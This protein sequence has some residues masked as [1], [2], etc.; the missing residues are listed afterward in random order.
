MAMMVDAGHDVIWID[1]NHDC[2]GRMGK[3]YSRGVPANTPNNVLLKGLQSVNAFEYS[4]FHEQASVQEHTTT[5]TLTDLPGDICSDLKYLFEPLQFASKCLFSHPRVVPV[6]GR[7]VQA[8]YSNSRGQ[9]SFISQSPHS[10]QQPFESEIFFMAQGAVPSFPTNLPAEFTTP[11]PH[12]SVDVFVNSFAVQEYLE[13]YPR[14]L[15]IQWAVVGS[16]HR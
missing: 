15:E 16:S 14:S 8:E 6:K 7:L 11:P 3:F 5:P 4:K 12:Q 10:L 2:M 1:E 13:R 9:W